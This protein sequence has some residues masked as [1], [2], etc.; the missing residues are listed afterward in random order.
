[1][2]FRTVI[3]VREHAIT[4]VLLHASAMLRDME[5]S[6]AERAWASIVRT[7]ALL[8]PLLDRELQRSTG[9][10]LAWYDVLLELASAGGRLRMSELGERV[11]LSRTRVSRIVDEMERDGLVA[12]EPNPEDGRSSYAALTAEGKRRYRE[13]GRVYRAGIQRELGE[14]VAPRELQALAQTLER[15]LE[16]S[17]RGSAK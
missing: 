15:L 16:E 4:Y 1:M 2:C 11:V 3:Y 7:H 10:P 6:Q 5:P 17:D 9:L 14:R 13:S 12:R 8:V